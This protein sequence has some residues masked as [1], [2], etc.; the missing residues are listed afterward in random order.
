MKSKLL[1]IIL[2]FTMALLPVGVNAAG[3]STELPG[4]ALYSQTYVLSCQG[5]FLGN[6]ATITGWR[7]YISYNA[8]GAAYV[9]GYVRFA[10]EMQIGQYRL[11]MTYEGYT[12]LAPYH[13]SLW[14]DQ[15]SYSF[16]IL[17]NTEGRMI[18]YEG[19]ERLTAP[20]TWGE[21]VC[22]W[23]V[24]APTPKSSDNSGSQGK[25][26]SYY[27]RYGSILRDG[28]CSY[29]VVEGASIEVCE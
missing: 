17:D 28:K 11:P 21:F 12:N 19:R 23:Q 6:Q 24:Y 3:E 27:G 4:S 10:G 2:V 29:I 25:D 20:T 18:I 9:D 26:Q 1:F 15:Q 5:Q 13:G 16:K 7:Q 8:L 14:V 22:R